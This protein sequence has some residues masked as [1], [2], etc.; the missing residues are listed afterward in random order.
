MSRW[1]PAS[2]CPSA[3]RLSPSGP[4][5]TA[6]I[7]HGTEGREGAEEGNRRRR[8]TGSCPWGLVKPH[9]EEG[10]ERRMAWMAAASAWPAPDGW[11]GEGRGYGRG[12]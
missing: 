3:I 8:R 1:K 12:R 9:Q 6:A 7:H 10:N 5:T 11:G 4:S 2:G